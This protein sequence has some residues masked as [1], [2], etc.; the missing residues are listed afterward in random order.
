MKKEHQIRYK[1]IIKLE[2]GTIQEINS[3]DNNFNQ[4]DYFNG[5]KTILLS[6]DSIKEVIKY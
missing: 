6:Q 2:D 5:V 3:I 1:S 4:F